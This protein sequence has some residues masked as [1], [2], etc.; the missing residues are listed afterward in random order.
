MKNITKFGCD[1]HI[2]LS[3]KRT[4]LCYVE[5]EWLE[6]QLSKILCVCGIVSKEVNNY[7]SV[8]FVCISI[9]N[10]VLIAVRDTDWNSRVLGNSFLFGLCWNWSEPERCRWTISTSTRTI[11]L[12]HHDITHHSPLHFTGTSTTFY[13]TV[14]RFTITYWK[15]AQWNHDLKLNPKSLINSSSC[16]FL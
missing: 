10:W 2:T 12:P 5:P 14:S 6:V 4:N 9:C 1:S 16:Y 8:L 13:I 11:P 15:K 7:Y 3:A